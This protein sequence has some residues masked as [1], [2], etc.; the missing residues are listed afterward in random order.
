[1]QC[2]AVVSSTTSYST[3]SDVS[4]LLYFF[5]S[6]VSPSILSNSIQ[7]I[8]TLDGRQLRFIFTFIAPGISNV[9]GANLYDVVSPFPHSSSCIP[10][11]IRHRIFAA[12]MSSSSSAL[13]GLDFQ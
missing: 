9:A 11:S 4:Y 1:F 6:F 12:S 2:P 13:R 5:F 7:F 3:P 10:P 8:S